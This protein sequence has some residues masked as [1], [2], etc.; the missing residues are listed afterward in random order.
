MTKSMSPSHNG[1]Q[2]RSL[3]WHE[4]KSF[5]GVRY[6]IRRL[7][8]L[9]RM[10]LTRQLRE[11]MLRYEFLKAGDASDE[12]QATLAELEVQ[13]LYVQW[14]VAEIAG[15]TIDGEA[16]TTPIL[17]E[18]GPENLINEMVGAIRHQLELSE[19]ERKNS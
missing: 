12:L 1:T 3:V 8:L 9:Q 16:A 18:K 15:L 13:K 4:S 19:E 6:A 10:D 2:Y 17:I 7:S 5:E 14:A 11:L